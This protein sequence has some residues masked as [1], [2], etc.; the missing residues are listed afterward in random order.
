MSLLPFTDL[1][2]KYIITVG[3]R[4]V[5]VNCGRFRMGREH[6]IPLR[7]IRCMA[8]ACYKEVEEEIAVVGGKAAAEGKS[9]K[10]LKK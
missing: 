3:N 8:K 6:R 4:A 2:N 10:G 7:R 5:N 1:P 9:Q